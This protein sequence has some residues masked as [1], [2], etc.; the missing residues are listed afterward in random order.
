MNGGN[1]HLLFLQ[2]VSAFHFKLIFSLPVGKKNLK[3][4]KRRGNKEKREKVK[5]KWKTKKSFSWFEWILIVVIFCDMEHSVFFIKLNS[6]NLSLIM[7]RTLRTSFEKKSIN[8]LFF[9]IFFM[10]FFQFFHH[11]QNMTQGQFI[12]GVRLVFPSPRIV[13]LPNLENA[14]CPITY[15]YKSFI[16]CLLVMNLPPLF[17]SKRRIYSSIS[18][19]LV[20]NRKKKKINSLN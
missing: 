14:I 1:H 16:N 18:R 9:D 20:Y 17:K 12:N 2:R 3:N 10:D 5:R 15:P 7:T 4:W 8:N 13:V 6:V 19:P 11:K